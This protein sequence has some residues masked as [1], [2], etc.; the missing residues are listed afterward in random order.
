MG[1]LRARIQKTLAFV[2]TVQEA[3]Y[4]GATEREVSLPWAPGKTLAGDDW[5]PARPQPATGETESL[6]R[7]GRSVWE[8]GIVTGHRFIIRDRKANTARCSVLGR[9]SARLDLRLARLVCTT[10]GGRTVASA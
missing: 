6:A 10:R 8:R 2:D 1:E 9:S 3:Q 7:A 5:P 4:A